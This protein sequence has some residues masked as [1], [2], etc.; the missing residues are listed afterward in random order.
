MSALTVRLKFT[1]VAASN[2]KKQQTPI[3]VV[4]KLSKK[5][6]IWKT[7]PSPQNKKVAIQYATISLPWTF[8]R[9]R[10]NS[11]G[12]QNSVNTRLINILAGV[13]N[14]SILRSRLRK[15]KINCKMDWTGY[16]ESDIFDF[17]IKKKKYDVKTG[18]IYS[19]YDAKYGRTPFSPTLVI[20]HRRNVGAG[21]EHKNFFPVG[22]A[23]SQINP[24]EKKD[25]YIFGL[26]LVPIDPRNKEARVPEMGDCG[27][28]C[29]APYDKARLFFHSKPCIL[30]REKAK[31]GFFIYLRWKK[32]QATLDAKNITITFF[33]EWNK[34][35][36]TKKIKLRPGKK[37]M[38]VKGEFSSLSTIRVDSP[39]LLANGNELEIKVKNNF[40]DEVP[41]STNPD[42][43]LNDPE[44]TWSLTNESFINLAVHKDYTVYWL[45]HIPFREFC[46]RFP[47]Y[48]SY[49]IFHPGARK[50]KGIHVNTPGRP[51]PRIVQDF[52]YFDKIRNEMIAKGKNVDWPEFKPLMTRN[53]INF[54]LLVS[55]NVG[56][57]TVGPQTYVYP[58]G[59]G[60]LESQ[61]YVLPADLDIMDSL[62][63]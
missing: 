17:I 42:I 3:S 61:L 36:C 52:A 29:S 22:V 32:E 38:K 46:K 58:S 43:N 28:W 37:F 51:T 45:G 59:Y 24:K 41:K 8:D 63:K 25:S 6:H 15:D 26:T 27:F 5:S 56:Y 53:R 12:T 7:Q 55:A 2:P 34:N 60:F 13:L 18:N 11:R 48:P 16:R 10:Y 40:N 23:K 19:N 62:I 39:S 20:K 54:G 1:K 44:F 4:P 50:V 49:F 33:G 9:M 31:K 21:A 30:A 47:K 57:V 14:Q 35:P